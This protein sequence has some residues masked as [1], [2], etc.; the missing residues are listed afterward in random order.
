MMMIFLYGLTCMKVVIIVLYFSLVLCGR[1]KM[2]RF[3]L[4]FVCELGFRAE[5]RERK[6]LWRGKPLFGSFKKTRERFWGVLKGFICPILKFPQIGGF[7]GVK[8]TN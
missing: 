3:S 7:W 5:G 4:G 1:L 8:H 2:M 6:G